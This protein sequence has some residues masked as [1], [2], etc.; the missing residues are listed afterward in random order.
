MEARI[1]LRV[2]PRGGWNGGERRSWADLH[3]DTQ[4]IGAEIL[5]IKDPAKVADIST[6]CDPSKGVI[7]VEAYI[8]AAK[9]GAAVDWLVSAF[10]AAMEAVERGR[11]EGQRQIELIKRLLYIEY[12][13]DGG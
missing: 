11:P 6:S 13:D 1:V 10:A 8:E 4:R 2:V 12:L 3:A 7:E 9:E 5:A